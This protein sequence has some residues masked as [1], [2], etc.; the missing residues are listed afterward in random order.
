ML[1]LPGDDLFCYQ[2]SSKICGYLSS[3]LVISYLPLDHTPSSFHPRHPSR[4]VPSRDECLAGQL[5]GKSREIQI[6]HH[7]T[8]L[9]GEGDG[10]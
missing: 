4:C 9:S 2:H 7:N 3:D 5:W 8:A 6:P 1:L 10:I